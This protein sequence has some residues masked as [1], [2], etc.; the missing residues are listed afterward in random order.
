MNIRAQSMF[1]V[2]I[3]LISLILTKVEVGAPEASYAITKNSLNT[4]V[5][6]SVSPAANLSYERNYGVSPPKVDGKSNP[7]R[8]WDVLDPM[9]SAESV[10]IQSLG[11]HFPFLHYNS[12]NQWS[13]ASITKLFTA[14]VVLDEIGENKK[15]PVS[16]SAV[17]TEGTAGLLK[18]GE[19]YSARDLLKIMLLTS[20]NDAATAFEEYVGGRNEFVRL[21][22][23]KILE[24]GLKDTILYDASGLSDLNVSTASDLLVLAEYIAESK[25]EI[26]NWTRLAQFLVQPINNPTTKTLYNINPFIEGKNFLGGKTG[27]LESAREN[28]VA[29]FSMGEYRL[30]VVLLGSPNRVNEVPVFLKWVGEAYE[31]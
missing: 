23:K 11:E 24:L 29:V 8:K 28:L 27:T 2:I 30:V 10:L 6:S 15:I 12:R 19:V 4:E 9:I 14:V 13:I 21:L 17:A 5:I 7:M 31:F 20:S 25:P 22:N 16:N 26:F 3:V 18:S 1:L